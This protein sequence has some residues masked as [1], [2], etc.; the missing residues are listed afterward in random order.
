MQKRVKSVVPI[1]LTGL[2]FSIQALLF[3]IYSIVDVV[4]IF[5]VSIAGY[6]VFNLLIRGKVVEM[7]KELSFERTSDAEANKV[8]EQGAAYVKRLSAIKLTIGN[9]K[10]AGQIAHLQEVAEQ[11]LDFV[12]K[13]PGHARKIS[14]FMDYYFPT[15]LKFLDSYTELTGKASRGRNI[16]D[17]LD[18]ISESLSKI[19]E[20]FEHQLDNL[21]SDKALD[22]ATDMAVLDSIMKREGLS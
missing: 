19:E 5:A 14:T 10:L 3:S 20:A 11:I 4:I 2:V 22:I 6:F 18:K 9:S 16:S 8:L 13:S 21:Y 17:T 12:A 7:P 1:Y 15:A